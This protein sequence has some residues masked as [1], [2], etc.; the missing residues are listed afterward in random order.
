MKLICF[1]HYTAG[2]LLCDILRREFSPMAAN[3]GV[4]SMAHSL[5]KIGDS[6]TV[7]TDFDAELLTSACL[8]YQSLDISIGTHCWPGNIDVTNYKEVMLITTE[9][10][11]SKVYRWL[12]A[13]HLYFS[14]I[15][16]VQK[17]R[18]MP[19]IDKQRELAKNYL[20][21]FRVVLGAVNIE[22]ADLVENTNEF[23]SLLQEFPTEPHLSRW[24]ET[25]KFLYD[26][27]LWNNDLVQ[28]Y[29]EA[30]FEVAHDRFYKYY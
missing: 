26:S 29:Y 7:F 10:T 17:L 3:G 1:P 13:W 6:N 30:E 2:G 21:P 16:E 4:G 12:R 19:L 18:G 11:K 14:K 24:K 28:R 25:N 15:P 23:T 5:G 8:P 9:T 22:F 20:I 27:N